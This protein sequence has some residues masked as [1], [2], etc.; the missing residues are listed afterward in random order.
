MAIRKVS[1]I[2][3]TCVG[4]ITKYIFQVLASETQMNLNFRSFLIKIRLKCVHSQFC[5]KDARWCQLHLDHMHTLISSCNCTFIWI[6][7][8]IVYFFQRTHR[9]TGIIIGWRWKNRESNN[10]IHEKQFVRYMWI[11]KRSVE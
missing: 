10:G 11:Y 2:Y 9:I 8:I 1:Y 5:A 4:K 3:G 7:H 6:I